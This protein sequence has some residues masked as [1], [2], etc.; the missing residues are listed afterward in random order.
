MSKF[1]GRRSSIGGDGYGT[2]DHSQLIH[3]DADDHLQYLIT[4]A[5]RTDT[6]PT[7]GINKTGTGSGD[8]F[9]LINAGSGAALYIRQTS[10]TTDADAAVDI[11][12][13]GNVGRGLS[14]SSETSDPILPLVQFSAL[15]PS[16]DEPVLKITHASQDGMA[17]HVTGDAYVSSQLEVGE[18]VKFAQIGYNPVPLGETGIYVR[19]DGIFFFVDEDG[20]HYTFGSDLKHIHNAL[21][22]IRKDLDGYHPDITGTEH[23][24]QH[25]DAIQT[26]IK[27][28]DGYAID[29]TVIEHYVQHSEAFQIIL[30]DLDGYASD[31]T[32][33]EHYKQ[34]GDTMQEILGALDGYHPD[35]TGTEHYKQHSEAITT[36]RKELDGYASDQTVS[37]HYKQFG[38]IFN[39]IINELDGY[40]VD[41]TV[42]EHYV[43]HS[44]A[45]QTI[46]KDLDGYA[47]DQTVSEHYAQHSKT[48]HTIL[49]DLDGYASDQTVSEHYSQLSDILQTILKELDGY[50][51][52]QTIEEHYHQHNTILNT[53]LSDMDGY[54]S[55]QTVSEHYTQ[56]SEAIQTILKD[57]DGYVI[58]D[59]L[60]RVSADDAYAGF[61]E[62]KLIGGDHI[63]LSVV[64]DGY[65]EKIR[66]DSTLHLDGYAFDST[67]SEHYQQHSEVFQTIRKELDGYDSRIAINSSDIAINDQRI[68]NLD[69][70]TTEHYHQ[71][72]DVFQTILKDLDGYMTEDVMVKVSEEDGYTGYLEEK[73]IA[74]PGISIVK[75]NDGY[76]EQLRIDN[77][78][79][80]TIQEHYQQHSEVFH[81]IRK[82]LDGYGFVIDEHYTQHGDIFN[83]IIKSLDGYHPDITGTEH[84]HQHSEAITNI[85]GQLDGYA[86][87]IAG[88]DGYVAFFIEEPATGISGDN[89][90]YWNRELNRLEVNSTY[91]SPDGNVGIGTIPD[92]GINLHVQDPSDDATIYVRGIGSG[93]YGRLLL[94]SD[95]YPSYG[96]LTMYDNTG[97]PTIMGRSAASSLVLDANHNMMIHSGNPMYIGTGSWV[98]LYLWSGNVGVNT[99]NPYGRL[100]VYDSGNYALNIHSGTA[101]PIIRYS[102]S[103]TEH[104]FAQGYDRTYQKYNIDVGEASSGLGNTSALRITTNRKVGVGEIYGASAI[105]DAQLHV[106]AQSEGTVFRTTLGTTSPDTTFRI[107]TWSGQVV[108]ATENS[109]QLRLNSATDTVCVMDGLS[110]GYSFIG[111]GAPANGL[112]VEG[113]VG[114]GTTSPNAEL[115]LDGVMSFEE[116]SGSPSDDT[117]YGKLWAS[118]DDGHIWW[119]TSSGD[120]FDLTVDTFGGGG[121]G[122]VTITGDGYTCFI[123]IDQIEMYGADPGELANSTGSDTDGALTRNALN[124][125]TI[126]AGAIELRG[127]TLRSYVDDVIVPT[128]WYNIYKDGV[129]IKGDE[130]LTVSEVIGCCEAGRKDPFV[131]F[132]TGSIDLGSSSF[133]PIGYGDGVFEFVFYGDHTP[134]TKPIR[135]TRST[136]GPNIEHIHFTYPTCSYNSQQQTDVRG[137]QTF[138]VEVITSTDGYADAVTVNIGA[139]G[140]VQSG[141]GLTETFAGS[142]IWT[143]T[144]TASSS[145]GNG[146]ADITATAIDT[147][148]NFFTINTSEIGEALVSFDTDFPVIE[149]Y[150]EG[151]DIIYPP[152]QTCI[153]WG[154]KVDAYMSASDFTEIYYYSQNGRLSINDPSTYSEW[155]E[156]TW[157]QGSSGIEEN[158]GS[159]STSNVRIRARK[160]TNC[161]ESNRYI[162]VRFDDTPPAITSVRWRRN[163]AGSYVLTSP[164]LG[165]GTHGVRFIF[166]DP[167]VIY[168]EIIV[169]DENKGTLSSI[170]GTLPGTTFYATLTVD[171]EDT[172]GC[173]ELQLVTALNCSHKLP[174]ASDPIA[175]NDEEFC[176]D[177]TDLNIIRVEIDIDSSDGYWNDGY[178][179]SNVRDDDSDNLDNT[180]QA[181]ELDFSS[182]VQSITANDVLTRHGETVYTSVEMGSVI[183]TGDA[184]TFDASPWGASSSFSVTKHS[185][186]L[187]QAAFTTNLG[188]TRNDDQGAAIGR[189]SIFHAT[190]GNA[191]VTDLALNSDSAA[192]TDELSANGIDDIASYVSFTSDGTSDPSFK[193]STDSFRAFMP[194]RRVKIVDNDTSAT[195]RTIVSAEIDGGE[196]KITVDGGTLTAYT[197]AQSARAVPLG[198]TNAEIAAWDANNGLVAYIDDGAFTHL[199]LVDLANPEAFSQHITNDQL[200]ENN[201]GTVGVDLFEANF[202]GSKIS[203]P[204]THGGTEAN[205]TGAADSKYVW[206]SKKIRLTT[207]PTGVQGS[208]LRF[209]VFG[210]SAGTS[211]RNVSISATSDWDQNAN[212]FNLNNNDSQ[213]DIRISVDDP[214]A[215]TPPYTNANWF[216]TTDYEVSPQSAF[217]FGKTKDINLTFSPPSTDVVDKDI[218]IEITLTTNG[219]GKAPQIDMIGL[220]YLT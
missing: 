94:G 69:N 88:H 111:W 107:T 184:C 29:Q 112:I 42:I 137:G 61:L 98:G 138:S 2:D 81:T 38:D 133:L 99:T 77:A 175:S 55:D 134:D 150:E 51:A 148:S 23:Y 206:R 186:W 132:T 78:L 59:E 50:G 124:R 35:I 24:H 125:F 155:K 97:A 39:I 3:L 139:S 182:G 56:H 28:L 12:N 65:E 71:Y 144:V 163:D 197:V 214:F 32:V 135:V 208:N 141:V 83:T 218:Y 201:T 187:Y 7:S 145:Q 110:V 34:Y 167:L 142:G 15:E 20:Y 127:L 172:D 194:G 143:G 170:T 128:M 96:S 192:N 76:D 74:G 53:I 207:N 44:D 216:L 157:D 189:A 87:S 147:L 188:S 116:L 199:T 4:S 82:E 129:L 9:T 17:L 204:N 164:T 86:R 205:P 215:S 40:A 198:V 178:S 160:W 161:S 64:D 219:S 210:F 101:D 117:G 165:I 195:T 122:D 140:A 31:Q 177:T 153:K 203:V 130:P 14:V 173:T 104:V 48:I 200:T 190:G 62:D 85:R 68:T 46:L 158:I 185:A 212:K 49:K 211:Y 151:S 73:I 60:V 152:G 169:K 114:F 30:K 105:P 70:T 113:N 11:D 181:C 33:S 168:P 115:T 191:T 149:S 106:F 58:E 89:D 119:R 217:K 180:D 93:N 8:V 121:G 45:F 54:A 19:D 183:E 154:E 120:E 37:E 16:F 174:F 10:T 47:S 102:T 79:D 146:Y 209:M 118:S 176:I 75:I 26:I 43:Q 108:L 25:S 67:V 18:T 103:T 179:G 220:S 159:L 131:R 57:L 90:L 91:I 123:E 109:R 66:I 193:V 156:Y 22:T 27:E 41:K 5:V 166:D 126:G 213:I 52:D 171:S 63:A 202:W 72:G 92:Y 84:Y 1:I 196:G 80:Q 21:Q 100:E 6:S 136:L 36:I 13:T 162:Q 95:S